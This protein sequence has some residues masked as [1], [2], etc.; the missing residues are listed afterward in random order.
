MVGQPSRRLASRP[1]EEFLSEISQRASLQGSLIVDAT[2]GPEKLTI[3]ELARK[4]TYEDT[5]RVAITNDDISVKP[6]MITLVEGRH[7]FAGL[8][9]E[10]PH[11]HIED[12]SDICE[13][14]THGQTDAY[15]LQLF[16]FSLKGHAKKWW[17]SVPKEIKASWTKVKEAF[18]DEYYPRI[19][20]VN[21]RDQITTFAQ[22]E[23]E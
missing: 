1:S 19:K 15:K 21:L 22:M 20:I 11:D 8:T 2:E 9:D 5:S 7:Q 23:N 13:S 17:R 12:F 14:Q 16:R 3:T 6:E 18:I 10:D 4:H